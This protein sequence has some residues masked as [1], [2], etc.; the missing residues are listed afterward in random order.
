LIEREQAK[1][2]DEA[3]AHLVDL[4]VIAKMQG[5]TAVF[6]NRIQVIEEAFKRKRSFISRLQNAG[7]L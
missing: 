5:E 1:P 7:L 4:Q 2:Y 3:V 6:D